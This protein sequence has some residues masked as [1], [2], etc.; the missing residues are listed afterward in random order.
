MEF[1][2]SNQPLYFPV[3]TTSHSISATFV[4]I[5]YTITASAGAHGSIS[6]NGISTFQL[7]ERITPT[8]LPRILEITEVLVDGVFREL[9]QHTLSRVFPLHMC[10]QCNILIKSHTQLQHPPVRMEAFHQMV[11][12]QYCA[13]VPDILT[14]TPNPVTRLMMFW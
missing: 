5:T 9:F 7:R 6:P 10:N 2:R 4:Q 14:I 3:V 12:I 1:R 13:V 11:Q 8:T